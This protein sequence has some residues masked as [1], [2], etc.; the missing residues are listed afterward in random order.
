MDQGDGNRRLHRLIFAAILLVSFAI[1]LYPAASALNLS[2]DAVEYLDEAAN[3]AEGKFGLLAIKRHYFDAY[4][5]IYSGMDDRPPLFPLLAAGVMALGGSIPAVQVVNALIASL[6]AAVWYL[7]FAHLVSRRAAALGATAGS[8]SIWFWGSSAFA[9]TEP[10]SMLTA[11]VA[12]WIVSAGGWRRPAGA[13][14]LG[15]LCALGYLTRHGNVIFFPLVLGLFALDPIVF[16]RGDGLRRAVTRI[17]LALVTAAVLLSPFA[18]MSL[19]DFGDP[20]YD[21]NEA[22][23]RWGWNAFD[24]YVTAPPESI[25]ALVDDV[26]PVHLA[27]LIGRN[28]IRYL[29][30]LTVG[31]G[32]LWLAALAI[33]LLIPWLRRERPAPGVWFLLALAGL[34]LALNAFNYGFFEPRYIL[35]TTVPLYP[36]LFGA[37]EGRPR[38]AASSLKSLGGGAFRS[39]WAVWGLAVAAAVQGIAAFTFMIRQFPVQAVNDMEIRIYPEE[40]RQYEPAG[41]E[42]LFAMIEGASDPGDTVST[43]LPWLVRLFTGRPSALLPVDLDEGTFPGYLEAFDVRLVVLDRAFLGKPLFGRYQAILRHLVEA[44]EGELEEEGP[45]LLY[46]PG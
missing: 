45:F 4:P 22:T 25:A 38:P 14:L 33:P 46:R 40:R 10:L 19:R 13:A 15:A 27:K 20:F 29:Q 5:V 9:F 42:K 26:G 30:A 31:P 41:Y 18:V 39:T 44:G 28:V 21:P 43:R 37:L 24:R 7:A 8:F 16:N 17:V 3:T 32:G 11:A 1:R 34:N 23:L 2:P 12:A 35:L 6:A 36:L